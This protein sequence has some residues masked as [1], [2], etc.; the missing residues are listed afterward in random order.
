MSWPSAYLGEVCS[1]L[2]GFAFKSDYFSDEPV[3]LPIIRI[4][5]VLPGTSKTY[6]SGPYHADYLINNGDILIGM[7]G[8]FNRER[9]KSSAALL[10]QRV[11]RTI[12]KEDVLNN[13]YLYHALPTILKR[14]EEET[15]F[16]TVKHLS[17]AKL[18]SAEIPLPCW[19]SS[20][21]SRRF[22]IRP[23]NC[24]AS[25]SVPWSA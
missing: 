7:D 9:W 2:S 16:V 4:R 12:A 23:T 22:W 21:A 25:V 13:D 3:G 19:R 15:P 8:E 18:R 5:D 17:V 10:N 24:A 1:F 14:I 11:C 20:G 6:Y